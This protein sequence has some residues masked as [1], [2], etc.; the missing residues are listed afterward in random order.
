[1][2][3]VFAQTGLL[4]EYISDYRPRAAQ[5]QMA[6]AVWHNLQKVKTLLCEAGT[7]T[8]KTF[9]YLV[10]ALL[11]GQPTIISTGTRNLQDQLF[12]KDLP[13]IVKALEPLL[14]RKVNFSLLKGRSNYV[15]RYRLEKSAGGSWY[16]E[17]TQTDL[18]TLKKHY[19]QTRFA[20]RTEF[21]M[22]EEQ[23]PIWPMVTSTTENCL[24][25]HCPEHDQCYVLKAREQAVSADILIINHHLLMADLS[26][27]KDTLGDILPEAVNYIIDEAHQ[28]PDIASRFFSSRISSRQ[29]KSL[30]QD[31]HKELKN[32]PSSGNTFKH[33]SQ[34]VSRLL[35]DLTLVLN[36][37]QQR[38]N[39]IEVQKSIKPLVN[40]VS[41][42]LTRLVNVLI[43]L[44]P[45][46]EVLQHFAQRAEHLL[47]LFNE[48]SFIQPLNEQN[49]EHNDTETADKIHWFEC[50]S[51]GFEI[52]STPLTMGARF[53]A[54]IEQL[55]AAWVFTSATLTINKVTNSLERSSEHSSGQQ[56]LSTQFNYFATQLGLNQA[57]FAR[58]NSPFD[59]SRQAVL[60]LPKNMPM[61]DDKNYT[62][63]LIKT[64][65]PLIHWLEGRT[66]LLF[67]SYKAMYEARQLLSGSGLLLLVQGDAPKQQLLSYFKQSSNAVL[68]GT[69]SFWEGVD[70]KGSALSCVVLDKLPFAS[71]GDPV[72]QARISY[73]Q[74]QGINAFYQLQLPQA[75]MTLKQGAGR[76]IR[77]NN[78]K[79]ILVIADPRLINKNYGY[80]LRKSLPD[81]PVETELEQ[82]QQRFLTITSANIG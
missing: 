67:T 73:L 27:K 45:V 53:K 2:R 47:S 60:Y 5:Q 52:N 25:S 14:Q 68:L 69:S 61:P 82:V 72:L 71:P 15:C 31:V 44:A 77:D 22:L 70:V 79:G 13:L 20:E 36:R 39:W 32:Q 4:S 35:D 18:Q 8:G 1:M 51:K 78:D 62:R 3:A 50:T 19:K 17:R 43:K 46:N 10:P 74:Q 9:A 23:S 42:V 57:S 64:L 75:A 6:V 55:N 58:Y 24:G 30:L 11:S 56:R 29:I 7:G 59:Y 54:H 40:E 66:F 21:T 63:I 41:Y 33:L 65:L 37:Y 81:M 16:D 38:G 34:D 26:L 12:Y 48:L 28:L 76:L 80:Y 49:N